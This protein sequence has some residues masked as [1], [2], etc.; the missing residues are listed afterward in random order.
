MRR[1][2]DFLGEVELPDYAYYGVQ[3]ARAARN[4]PVSGIR[5][6]EELIHGYVLLKR[7][8]A[9]A[10]RE[11][12]VLDAERADAI[13]KASDAILRG[14]H[15]DQFP[16]DVF[17][18]GA[19]TSVNMNVNEVLANLALEYMGH[20][21]GEYQYVHPNDHVNKGQSTN[22]TFTSACHIAVVLALPSL[23]VAL[24]NLAA[25]FEAKS[26]E[27]AEVIKSGRTHL[28][29]AL[30]IML[31][32]E[33]GAYASAVRRARGRIEERGNDLYELEVGGT[34]VGTGANAHPLFRQT[35]FRIIAE[36]TKLPFRPSPN[37][38]E[39]LETRAQLGAF[40]SSLKELSVELIRI[41]ND[42]RLL[43]SG[44][45]TALG[46]IVLPAVQPGSSIMPGKVNPSMPE[47]LTMIAFQV[48]GDD[49][50]V[51]LASQGGQL[52]LNIWTPLIIHDVVSSMKHYS[53]FLPVFTERCIKGIV[54]NE[55]RCAYHLMNNPILATLLAPKIGYARS[56]ELAEES[57]ATGI[58][59]PELAVKKGLITEEESRE[60]F[61]PKEM[62]KVH[63][64]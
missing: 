23:L 26:Q 10:N 18:A 16:L 57:E 49:T 5:E 59:V 54:A 12:G 43:A 44:P 40:M 9:M 20:K 46:E 21:K 3:T 38:F 13:V 39:S 51:V 35:F 42:L 14:E 8:A 37:S 63:F 30:P 15:S 33:M 6:P 7:A 60:I 47:C 29:D 4:F 22:D 31:G 62:A 48:I 19:G 58:S 2:S 24:D 25:A 41:C 55:E 45:A 34:A 61:D 36:E 32:H 11:V 50:A 53:N 17:Q 64:Q 27:F 1:E 28:V 52:E 56:A